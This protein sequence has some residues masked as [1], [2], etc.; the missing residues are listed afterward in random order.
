MTKLKMHLIKLLLTLILFAS[1]ASKPVKSYPS[2][3][4]QAEY[5]RIVMGLARRHKG[6]TRR[7]NK[8]VV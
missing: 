5:R 3:I 6:R 2:S 4:K 1:A 8:F 7:Q